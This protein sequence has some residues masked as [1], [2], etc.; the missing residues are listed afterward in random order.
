MDSARLCRALEGA[1]H[2]AA[3]ER[4]AR[5]GKVAPTAHFPD[6][7]AAVLL[8]SMAQAFGYAAETLEFDDSQRLRMVGPQPRELIEA[9]PD[10]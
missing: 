2:R 5:K 4:M 1:F 9:K 10:A 7:A 8:G 3:E 6:P